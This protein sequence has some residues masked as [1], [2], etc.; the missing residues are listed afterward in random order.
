MLKIELGGP[1]RQY[2]SVIDVPRIFRTLT[3]GV[4]IKEDI[5]LVRRIVK[6]YIKDSRTIIL[7]VIL[8]PVDIATREILSIA[9]EADQLG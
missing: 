7:A 6:L 3:Y 8:A 4:I 1:S 5:T 9:E 2:L